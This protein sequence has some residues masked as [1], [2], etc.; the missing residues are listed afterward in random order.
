MLGV[1]EVSN[2]IGVYWDSSI[3]IALIKHEIK[4]GVDRTLIPRMI[5]EDAIKNEVTIYISR[6]TIV[7]VHKKRNYTSL[8][9]AEDSEVQANFFQ[10]EYIKKIDVDRDV[11]EKAREI[12]WRYNLRPNDAIHVASAK[13]VT[14]QVLHHWDGDFNN[15]PQDVMLCSEPTNWE[16]QT[17]F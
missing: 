17:S 3:W 12:A 14:A 2:P 16:R 11:A 6:L 10:H 15:V 5:I 8:T 1:L 4:N 7:E 13:K 9:E